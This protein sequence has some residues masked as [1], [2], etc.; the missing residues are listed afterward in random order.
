MMIVLY[1]MDFESVKHS[2]EIKLTIEIEFEKNDFLKI[3]IWNK[4]TVF[5]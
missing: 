3:W 4:K 5:W 2:W 1:V